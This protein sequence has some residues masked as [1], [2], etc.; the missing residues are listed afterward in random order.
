MDTLT[1]VAD[2]ASIIVRDDEHGDFRVYTHHRRDTA[3]VTFE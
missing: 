3:C 2:E 1:T